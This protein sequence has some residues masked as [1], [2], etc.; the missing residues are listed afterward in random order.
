MKRYLVLMLL[1][2][3]SL[4]PLSATTIT[5]GNQVVANNDKVCSYADYDMK[6]DQVGTYELDVV[7]PSTSVVLK[8]YSSST[9]SVQFSLPSGYDLLKLFLYSYNEDNQKELVT[10]YY[11]YL[12]DCDYEESDLGYIQQV[13]QVT[14]KLEDSK[15]VMLK[16]IDGPYALSYNEVGKRNKKI[17]FNKDDQASIEI[18]DGVYQFTEIYN[19]KDGKEQTH[20]FELEKKD[21]TFF[22]RAISSLDLNK[23]QPRGY[24]HLTSFLIAIIAALCFVA[25]YLL[26]KKTKRKYKRRKKKIAILKERK[27]RENETKVY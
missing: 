12:E 24:I 19:D 18:Q 6:F 8:T 4:T 11:F 3:L 20:Y 14:F 17:S 13:P 1:F 7:D 15:L 26:H 23:I 21:D 2:A 10:E 25:F 9:D 16:N 27:R 5:S 22:I